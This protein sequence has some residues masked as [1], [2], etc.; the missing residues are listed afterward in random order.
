M[1]PEILPPD[2]STAAL[3]DADAATTRNAEPVVS[4]PEPAPEPP[5]ERD[6]SWIFLNDAGELRSG[7]SI[8]IFL[9]L[10]FVV[11]MALSQVVRGFLPQE[12]EI[13]SA[14]PA[15]VRM[16]AGT[17]IEFLTLLCAGFLVAKMEHRSVLD[18]NLKGSGRLPHFLSGLAAGF[19]ALSLVVV[20]MASGGWLYFGSTALSG[21]TVIRYAVLWGLVFLFVGFSEEGAFRCYLQFTLTRGIGFWWAVGCMALMCG[22]LLLRSHGNGVWGVYLAALVGLPLCLWIYLNQSR[23]SSF[24]YAAWVTSTLFGFIHTGN[25]GENWIGI[26]AAALIGFVFCVSVRLTG[27]A[28][29]AIG[30]HAAW[31]WA[32]TY[33]FG[34]ADS[35]MVAQGHFL[36]TMTAGNPLWSGG[37]NGPEGSLLVI[38]VILLLLLLVYWLYARTEGSASSAELHYDS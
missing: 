2:Q 23:S 18:F 13:R 33:F 37:S 20:L 38:P 12:Q 15:P 8:L 3:R 14:I 26:F 28:W 16:L 31:D 27:S 21:V 35:G 24:W 29:W 22:D 34:T 4:E 36:T 19:V 7:F 25:N 10:V 5:A 32:E 6:I 17:I 9:F 30:C 1:E 11:G